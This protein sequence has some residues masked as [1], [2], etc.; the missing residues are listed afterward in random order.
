MKVYVIVPYKGRK[1]QD[2]RADFFRAKQ[3][4]EAHGYQVAAA[5][6]KPGPEKLMM[7]YSGEVQDRELYSMGMHLM[8]MA[9]CDAVYPVDGWD[10]APECVAE[11]Y[12]AQ[13]FGLERL[14]AL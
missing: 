10:S 8:H 6:D 7:P 4:L 5:L 12:A 9:C 13:A 14:E 2:A 3:R 1:M 11:V